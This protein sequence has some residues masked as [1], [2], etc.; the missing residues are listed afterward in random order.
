MVRISVPVSVT[1]IY[2]GRVCLYCV[3]R[4]RGIVVQGVDMIHG[5]E[6]IEVYKKLATKQR[7]ICIEVYNKHSIKNKN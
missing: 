6:S 7:F 5:L 2:S 3:Y 4:N 1:A